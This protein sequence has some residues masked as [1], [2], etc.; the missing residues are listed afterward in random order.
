[1]FFSLLLSFRPSPSFIHSGNLDNGGHVLTLLSVVAIEALT[2]TSLGVALSTSRAL[3]ASLA[4]VTSEHIIA[5]GAENLLAGGT[6]ESDVTLASEVT[7]GVPGR[8]V[9][10]SNVGVSRVA[11]GVELL[12]DLVVL[13]VAGVVGGEGLKGLEGTTVGAGGIIGNR[14]LASGSGE[15][16]VALA[17]SGL[18]VALATAGT[19]ENLVVVV[20]SLGG[21]GEG[22]VRGAG[23]ERA[24]SSGPISHSHR[25]GVLRL[26]LLTGVASAGVLGV[27]EASSV[28]RATVGAVSLGGD[29][30]AEKGEENEVELHFYLYRFVYKKSKDFM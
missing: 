19:L 25:G 20:V 23:T 10:S 3:T 16:G 24:I 2:D 15:A 5:R 13:V 7:V 18:A 29:E 4:T 1:M 8:I 22:T 26:L 11:A 17:V 12:L 6:S 27:V 28:A 14:E 9:L 21:G 30:H